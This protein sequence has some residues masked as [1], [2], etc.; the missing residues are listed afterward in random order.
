MTRS[1]FSSETE[2]RARWS[3]Q[4]RWRER[5]GARP[6]L[7]FQSTSLQQLRRFVADWRIRV[8]RDL[9]CYVGVYDSGH[10]NRRG[11]EHLKLHLW[12]Y[13]LG[14]NYITDADAT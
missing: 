10:L 11:R 14:R 6:T 7:G 2:R 12:Q 13:L 9:H 4:Q 3:K 5:R 8:P 1:P